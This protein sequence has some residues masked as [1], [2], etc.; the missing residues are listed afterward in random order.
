M[1]GEDDDLL[2]LFES[3]EGENRQFPFRS[4]LEQ[5]RSQRGISQ[6]EWV[7][8]VF[9]FAHNGAH[10]DMRYDPCDGQFPM[11]VKLR[12]YGLSCRLEDPQQNAIDRNIEERTSTLQSLPHFD[13]K[14][15]GSFL[16]DTDAGL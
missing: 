11:N 2:F 3:S 10:L 12:T 16:M 14:Q 7:L 13:K 4:R 1:G 5:E 6:N 15:H 8:K 9:C